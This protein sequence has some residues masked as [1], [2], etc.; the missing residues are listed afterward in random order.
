MSSASRAIRARDRAA[1][2]RCHLSLGM[3]IVLV[4]HAESIWNAEGRWQGQA[5]IPLSDRGEHEAR[6]LGARLAGLAFDRRVT[7]DL[8]RARTTAAAIA[9]PPFEP[10]RAWR[11]IDLGD[12]GGLHH[13]E[14]QRRFPHELAAMGAGA[15]VKLGG[16]ESMP[17]FEARC[18]RALADLVGTMRE[19]ERALVLTHGGVIRSIVMRILGVA[20]RRAIVGTGNTAITVLRVRDAA[21][22][23]LVTYNCDAHLGR[24]ADPRDLVV[25]DDAIRRLVAELAL[26][27]EA[28]GRLETPRAGART[29]IARAGTA[30]L[31]RSFAVPALLG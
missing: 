28:A 20:G 3:E 25:E 11:E 15:D 29:R 9:G 14:V 16:A 5:D 13:D 24:E 1:R 7:S 23:S 30:M 10:D 21:R 6:A 2:K 31:L 17:G 12:W 26:A 27:P 18:T 22:S 4:R 8:V 19:G